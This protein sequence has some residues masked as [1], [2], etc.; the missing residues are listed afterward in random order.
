[1]ITDIKKLT[2]KYNG[3]TVGYLARLDGK[4]MRAVCLQRR[5]GAEHTGIRAKGVKFCAGICKKRQRRD[6]SRRCRFFDFL[7][8]IYRRHLTCRAEYA[9]MY[10]RQPC[11]HINCGAPAQGGK[12]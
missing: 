2:V 3:K 10:K 11:C 9:I 1:M 8:R 5:R 12:Q 6:I 7:L 4:G